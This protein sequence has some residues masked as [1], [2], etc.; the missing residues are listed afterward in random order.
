MPQL[1]LVWDNNSTNKYTILH[2]AF[3]YRYRQRAAQSKSKKQQKQYIPSRV[4][5]KTWGKS[6]QTKMRRSEP[7]TKTVSI[8]SNSASAQ[9]SLCSRWSMER[10]F[11]QTRDELMTIVRSVP[12]SAALSIFASSPQSVQYICLQHTGL[13]H[14]NTV[15]TIRSALRNCNLW[16]I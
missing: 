12:S 11:G 5:P 15:C 7:V 14:Y 10:P 6:S 2:S 4:K 16:N 8:L 3:T 1:L 9:Y 13:H